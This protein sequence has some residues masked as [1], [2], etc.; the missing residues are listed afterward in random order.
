VVASP[1]SFFTAHPLGRILNK[2]SSDLGQI[3][4]ELPVVLFDCVESAFLCLGSIAICLAALPWVVVA[5]MP[6]AY[7]M[8]AARLHFLAS[9]RELKR[10]ESRTKSPI[11]EHF[12]N[13][14]YGLPTIRAFHAETATACVFEERLERN[15][16][17]WSVCLP[18]CLSLSLSVCLSACLFVSFFVC[19][20]VCL[21]V[22]LSVCYSELTV[23]QQV[24]LAA[25]QPL[26]GLLP[27][28]HQL[29]C[30][31]RRDHSGRGPQGIT[32]TIDVTLCHDNCCS[33]TS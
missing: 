13:S 29:W 6:L 16:R 3:D 7:A 8:Y 10:M 4:E 32:K 17:A 19:L 25:G 26:G 24:P 28:P 27:R 15:G 20:S 5:V 9:A 21:S 23:L 1:L 2:F 11:F 33:L 30:A 22:H 31:G 12:G 14:L 18:V